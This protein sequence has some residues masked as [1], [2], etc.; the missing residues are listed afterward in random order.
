MQIK[1]ELRAAFS[2]KRR[3][4]TDKTEKD[5]AICSAFL[6]SDI[7]NSADEILCYCSFG[8]EIDTSKIIETALNDGKK[9]YLPKCTDKNGSMTFYLVSDIRNLVKG[10]FGISEPDTEKCSP[11]FEFHNAVC[12]V[13]G[14]SFDRNGHRLGY[15]KGYYD[16]FLEKFTIKSAGLCYNDLISSSLPAEKYD[17]PVDYI[18]TETEII[19]V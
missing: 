10:T 7:Y 15:G 5:N 6:N 11:A 12:V 1:K 17:L 4:I 9:L 19:K 8:S 18:F 14:L 13:P 3:M 2:E 16:R